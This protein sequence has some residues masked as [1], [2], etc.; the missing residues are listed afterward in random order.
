MTS[1]MNRSDEALMDMRKTLASAPGANSSESTMTPPQIQGWLLLHRARMRDQ[2]IV[3]VMT[4]GSLNIKLVEKSLLDLFT[5]DV[6]Q[7]V[8]RSHG[9][10]SGNPRKQH[11]F[12]AIEEVPEDDDETHL[13]DDCCEN[14]DPYVDEGG[15]FLATEDVVSDVDDDLVI[16]D[17]EHHATLFSYREA[18][19]L[20]KEAPVA[21]AFYPVVV[22]IH[23][24][25]PTGRGKGDSSSGKTVVATVEE[26]RMVLD[27]L[28]TLVA[29]SRK[30]KAADVPDQLVTV[31]RVHMSDSSVV[32]LVIGHVTAQRWMMVPPVQRSE[33]LEPTPMVRGPAVLLTISVVTS[34]LNFPCDAS[35]H[36]DDSICFDFLCG[37]AIPPVQDDDECE[38]HAAFLVDSE[39]FGVL[40]CDASTSFGSAEGAEA[41]FSKI[42][43]NDTRIPDVDPFGGRSFNVEMVLRQNIPVQTRSSK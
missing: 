24:D 17:E 30:G 34:V 36:L 21:R 22:P 2:D 32:R 43:E 39:G 10:D 28:P 37:A 5:D 3:G 38:A 23:P 19:D 11:A 29:A 9:K 6:L 14:D 27:D 13:I 12:E 31:H 35:N 8:D 15:N 41:L 7:S 25:K 40:D 16:H 20:M 18:R 26:D 33:I 1:W 42:L 4:G